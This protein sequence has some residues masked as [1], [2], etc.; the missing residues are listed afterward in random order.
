MPNSRELEFA[1]EH[2]REIVEALTLNVQLPLQ[3]WK[4]WDS[5][6]MYLIAAVP[7]KIC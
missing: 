4:D 7:P 2:W 6:S 3:A 1:K 5:A